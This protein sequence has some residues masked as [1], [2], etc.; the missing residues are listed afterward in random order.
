MSR[1]GL[2][3]FAAISLTTMSA[4]EACSSSSGSPGTGGSSGTGGRISTGGS[5][6]AG[7]NPGSGGS[8]NTGNS[9][10][11]ST[12]TGG[13]GA[14]GS[15]TGGSS[16]LGGSSPATDAGSGV[17]A[18]ID[19]G[20]GGLS[21]GS[22]TCNGASP[23]CCIDYPAGAGPGGGG[24][25]PTYSCVAGASAC[26]DTSGGMAVAATCAGSA[27]CTDPANPICCGL[28]DANGNYS[29]ACTNDCSQ[30]FQLCQSSSD[31]AAGNTCAP[32]FGSG[33]MSCSAD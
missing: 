8:V 10:G 5:T 27:D 32:L 21:C 28:A 33:P 9:S 11:G 15:G 6:G 29:N 1:T 3:V 22:L 12:A 20:T 17:D 26:Q 23:V 25:A 18:S 14:G 30:G 16:G 19:G 24:A 31:C 7:G 13:S 4:F 2:I